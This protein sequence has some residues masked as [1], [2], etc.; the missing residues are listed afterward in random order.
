MMDV[1]LLNHITQFIF[2]FETFPFEGIKANCCSDKSN[3]EKQI[4]L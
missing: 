1:L 3:P 2:K 4:C